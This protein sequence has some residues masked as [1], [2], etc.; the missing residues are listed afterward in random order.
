MGAFRFD[1]VEIPPEAE[2][3][4]TEVRA[5]L[6]EEMPRY[7]AHVRAGSWMRL[8]PAF[9]RKLA[10][11]GWVGMAWSKR[12]GG[13]ERSFLERYVVLEELL[14]AGA[15]VGAHWIADRQSAPTIL[16]F[17]TEAQKQDIVPRIAKGE[18]FFC[19]GMSEPDSGS[20]LA[21]TR[22]KAEKTESGWR[23]NGTKLWTTGAHVAH[24]MIGLFRTS[25]ESK[26]GGL[27]QFLIPMTTPGLTVRP[28]RD[29]TG[30][31]HFN[32]CSFVDV[33][34]PADAVLGG[35][36]QGWAQ[37]TSELAFER[38][39]PERFLSSMR[40]IVEMIRAIGP[41]PDA[42][43][44]VAIGQLTARLVALRRMSLSVAGMLSRGEDPALEAAVVKDV[45][46][47]F[48][49]DIPGIAASLLDAEPSMD[50][51]K[52]YERVLAELTMLSPSF[53]LRGGTRE[54]LRGIIA[55]G[56]GLR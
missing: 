26:H 7:P 2:A 38:S 1:A 4:R 23:L 8:E 41:E 5:F 10:S 22:A 21:A 54:I 49:Q 39:G 52:T 25:A 43:Q 56:L 11:R 46:A 6:A 19:I 50:E 14:S 47:V 44:A 42:R 12:Y 13:H 9:S 18:A 20:D 34:L 31:A 48:E 3:L 16:K 24:Y 29:L 55:R 33:E 30:D 32:E 37:V 35:E 53:S 15:P 27:T 40:L 28:I 51:A 45:G 17:G 36:G